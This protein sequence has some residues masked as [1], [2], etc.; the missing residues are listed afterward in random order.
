MK[1]VP[2]NPKARHLDRNRAALSRGVVE[3]SL[4]FILTLIHTRYFNQFSSQEDTPTYS[5]AHALNSIQA[6]IYRMRIFTRYILRE[7]TSY[8]LL[9]GAL[10]TFVLFMRDLGR[11]LELVVRE[12]ATRGQVVLV[13]AYT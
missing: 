10:F 1:I 3:R 13:F 8:A 11:I 6:T 4:H 5:P 7:V 2:L 9:G 12:S